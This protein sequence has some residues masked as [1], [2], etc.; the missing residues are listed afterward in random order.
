MTTEFFG[1]IGKLILTTELTCVT[2]ELN[3]NPTKLERVTITVLCFE[4]VTFVALLCVL[5]VLSIC[6]EE[7]LTEDIL[8]PTVV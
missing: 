7:N 2:S 3:D 1:V 6:G 4:S 8:D 5:A